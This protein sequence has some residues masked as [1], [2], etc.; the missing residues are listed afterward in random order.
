MFLAMFM[1]ISSELIKL[2]S[3]SSRNSN[4][5]NLWRAGLHHAQDYLVWHLKLEKEFARQKPRIKWLQDDDLNS[6]FFH[7]SIREKHAKF[8]N[9]PYE[10]AGWSLARERARCPR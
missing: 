5:T 3:R 4:W 9:T 8:G 10:G 2:W 7:A 6:K 1:I